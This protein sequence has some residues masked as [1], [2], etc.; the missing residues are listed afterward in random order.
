MIVF[1]FLEIYFDKFKKEFGICGN[2][3]GD[4]N[5]IER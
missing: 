2:R 4:V 5:G 1:K 3:E